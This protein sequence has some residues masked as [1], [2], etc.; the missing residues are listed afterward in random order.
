MHV[1]DYDLGHLV[2]SEQYYLQELKI[3]CKGSI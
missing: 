3:R 1:G 2:S